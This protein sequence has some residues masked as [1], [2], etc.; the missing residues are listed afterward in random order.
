M[1]SYIKGILIG[2]LALWLLMLGVLAVN[3]GIVKAGMFLTLL[4][5]S[6][7]TLFQKATGGTGIYL[8]GF[9]VLAIWV[10][11]FAK[12]KERIK[13]P[14]SRTTG[15]ETPTPSQKID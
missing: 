3:D 2:L 8:V 14:S 11:S 9:A 5:K 4:T 15:E 10:W 1:W 13:V 6:A 12:K 7:V